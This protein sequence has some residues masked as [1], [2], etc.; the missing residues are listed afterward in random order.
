V[1]WASVKIQTRQVFQQNQQSISDC[2]WCSHRNGHCHGKRKF[3]SLFISKKT[4]R[5]NP[6]VFS[7]S[8][9]NLFGVYSIQ[10]FFFLENHVRD[11]IGCGSTQIVHCFS[12]EAFERQSQVIYCLL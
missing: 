7:V 3:F 11:R 5:I 10:S 4:E 12:K 8:E 2:C 1:H 9:N 6:P